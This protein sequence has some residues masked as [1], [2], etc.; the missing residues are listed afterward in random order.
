[1]GGGEGVQTRGHS[2]VY[3]AYTIKYVSGRER[4]MSI[5]RDGEVCHT[6]KNISGVIFNLLSNIHIWDRHTRKVM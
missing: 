5:Q 3:K 2:T 6:D 4:E 1:M